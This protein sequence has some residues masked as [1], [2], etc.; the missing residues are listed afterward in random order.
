ME[1]TVGTTADQCDSHESWSSHDGELQQQQFSV[2]NK[3]L[4]QATETA[5]Q[6]KD[7]RRL[8]VQLGTTGKW[9]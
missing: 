5:K 3:L 9:L 2:G 4:Q 8:R 6:D 1:P 7:Y